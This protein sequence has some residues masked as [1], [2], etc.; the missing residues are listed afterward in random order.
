MNKERLR[1]KTLIDIQ[2]SKQSTFD[3]LPEPKA[4]QFSNHPDKSIDIAQL[5]YAI[6]EDEL[7][8]LAVFRLN[9]SKNSFSNLLLDLYFDSNILHTYLISIPPSKLL[10]DELQFPV[11]LE[12]KGITPGAH[13]IKVEM[14][15]KWSTG[16]KLTS[17]S[18]YILVQYSPMRK[19]ERY[20]KIPIVRKIDGAFRIILPGE[21]ALLEELEK[22]R[23]EELN[24]KRDHW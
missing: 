23:R 1:D 12:M 21:E 18:K 8:L 9:P 19:E 11:T 4:T 5:E 15:E 3:N 6:N 10:S 20:I 7:E 14:Y 24:S 16:E 2:K 13:A 22:S 17:A